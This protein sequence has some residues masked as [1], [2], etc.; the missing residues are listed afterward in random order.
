MFLRNILTLW[1]NPYAQ[2]SC[3]GMSK[4]FNPQGTW[5]IYRQGSVEY[6][7]G[8][9]IFIDRDQWSIF[10]VLNFENQYFWALVSCQIFLGY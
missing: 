10:L 7:L 8:L 4:I 5:H 9:G 2:N 3:V 1:P 6:F